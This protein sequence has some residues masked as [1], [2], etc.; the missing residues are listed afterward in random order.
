MEPKVVIDTNVIISAAINPKGKPG[1]I[2][3][4]IMDGSVIS[5][6]SQEIL[7]ELGFKLLSE[8][9]LKYIGDASKALDL[10]VSFSALSI[11]V[12][13]KI[14]FNVSPDPDD[15]KF[16][17]VVY[18]AKAD[19]LISGNIKHIVNLRDENKEFK[20]GMHRF[21]ILTPGEFIL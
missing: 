1:K 6:T 16:F 15:N 9:V 10:L 5:Y 17:N 14:H 13:P 19:Y 11:L 18:E 3:D 20:L 2:I 8:R 21:K 12:N 4:M 7:E